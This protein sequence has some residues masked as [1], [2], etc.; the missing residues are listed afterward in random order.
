MEDIRIG[1]DTGGT[2]TDFVIVRRGRLSTFKLPSTPAN[3]SRAILEGLHPYLGPGGRPV[4]IHGT[5]VATNALLERKGARTALVTTE[6]FEDVL[7]IGRQTRRLLYS[8][9]G[10]KRRPVVD[11]GLSLGVNERTTA[12]GR[13]ERR[14][15]RSELRAVANRLRALG[16]EAVAV[17]LI[18]AYANGENEEAVLAALRRAGLLACASS[19]LLPEYREYERTSTTAVN[20]YLMPILD[21]YLETLEAGVGRAELRVMQSNEGYIRAGKAKAEPIRTAL[22]GP[23]G[24]AVGALVL[25]RAAGFPKIVSFDMGG[26]STDVS[27]I[28]GKLRRTNEALVGDF[29]VRL[30]VIDIHS[31]GAGGGSIATVDPGGSLRVG[32]ESAGADPGPACYGRGD[33]PTVTD[34]NLVLGRIDP[35]FFLGGRMKIDSGR[36][37]EA[38]ARLASAIGKSTLQAAQGIVDIAN[39]NMEK[40]IRVISIE[41]G[42]DPRDFTLFSFGGAGG[43]HAVDMASDL[44]MKGV[45]APAQA[46]VLSAF[47]LLMADAVKDYSRSILKLL[48]QVDDRTIDRHFRELARRGRRELRDDGFGDENIVLERA[49]DLR[50]YG[51]SYELTL[52]Y[53]GSLSS[54]GSSFHRAHRGA[55]A[56]H[57]PGGQVEIVNLRLKARGLS[58]K[59]RL[60]K[61]PPT[62]SARPEEAVLKTQ[63]IVH[64]GRTRR[65]WVYDRSRLSPGQ[66]LSGPALIVDAGSTTFLPP[67]FGLLVDGYLNLLIG[68]ARP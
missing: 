39:A 22:S 66:R 43:M 44:R 2:F 6:G 49:A 23:A 12:Q 15:R 17:S 42:I 14:P 40:A 8:L 27:L 53:E 13:V 61:R 11:R 5:T 31:V 41:R 30:P 29:P 54:L 26:T 47:G 7:S 32:P 3:P 48:S 58:P 21:R 62:K 36:S 55:Y 57:H 33:L 1:V 35:D 68:R 52:S 65:G 51:Q 19:R 50:Y 20:A 67:G 38:V 16:V 4:V 28:D 25:G 10:E 34:A 37:R 9:R 46:G 60:K 56:Y 64:G 59:I 63:A 45:L 24:G 18:H